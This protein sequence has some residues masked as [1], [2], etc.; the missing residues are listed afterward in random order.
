MK[1]YKTT[2]EYNSG[3]EQHYIHQ[4]PKWMR[5]LM[6]VRRGTYNGFTN[7]RMTRVLCW[8]DRHEWSAFTYDNW[9]DGTVESRQHQCVRCGIPSKKISN[10]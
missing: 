1:P 7:T 6:F 5:F 3:L 10:G 9:N 8:F 4:M 2:K